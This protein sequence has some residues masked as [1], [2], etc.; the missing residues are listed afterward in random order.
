[1]NEIVD[2]LLANEK[3][4]K[5]DKEIEFLRNA[6]RGITL[7]IFI[8]INDKNSHIPYQYDSL[9]SALKEL[10]GYVFPEERHTQASKKPD[11]SWRDEYKKLGDDNDKT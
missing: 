2:L 11:R 7:D 3:I 6:R 10:F 8:A 9:R 1:M 5:I 4:T